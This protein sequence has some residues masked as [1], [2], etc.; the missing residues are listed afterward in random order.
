VVVSIPAVSPLTA[1]MSALAAFSPF[2]T[3]AVGAILGSL[4][5]A[6]TAAPAAIDLAVL[7]AP[8]ALR[9]DGL[10]AVFATCIHIQYVVNSAY[11]KVSTLNKVPCYRAAVASDAV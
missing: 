10:D 3:I 1:S 5:S 4:P 7:L 2:S 9:D 6:A 11:H 8:L